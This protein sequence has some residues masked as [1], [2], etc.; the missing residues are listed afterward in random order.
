MAMSQITAPSARTQ[1]LIRKSA[2][3]VYQAFIDPNQ[4][5]KFWFS[6][7]SGKLVQGE[8]VKWFWDMYGFSV[9]V[10]VITLEQD[11]RILVEWP[12]PVEW[13]FSPRGTN[14][15]LVTIVANGFT[16][17]ADEQVANAIDSMGGFSFVLAG[18]K[19]WLEHGVQLNLVADHNPD[20]KTQ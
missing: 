10:R 14:A 18:C 16:G 13:V 9:D 17:T 4:T 8:T 3:E 5:S 15:T 20:H 11:R 12:T 7:G 6:R 2:A 1:M 19:A